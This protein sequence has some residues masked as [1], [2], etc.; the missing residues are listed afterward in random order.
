MAQQVSIAARISVRA[1]AW[2][3]FGSS[4]VSGADGDVRCEAPAEA[5]ALFLHAARQQARARANETRHARPDTMARRQF[6]L[7][8]FLSQGYGPKTWRGN[9]PG[10]DPARRMPPHLFL[11][12]APG[13][14]PA[15]FHYLI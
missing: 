7:S 15:P 1:E 14:E 3:P 9:W 2:S 13:L 5:S 4:A 12:L 11:H 6:H 10:S 8:W